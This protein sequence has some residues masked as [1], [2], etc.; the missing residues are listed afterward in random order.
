MNI[1]KYTLIKTMVVEPTD[2]TPFRVELVD[3]LGGETAIVD[4]DGVYSPIEN[5]INSLN[6]WGFNVVGVTYEDIIICNNLGENYVKLSEV[7]KINWRN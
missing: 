7:E 2:D 5:A 4:C 1:K 3:Y 6:K